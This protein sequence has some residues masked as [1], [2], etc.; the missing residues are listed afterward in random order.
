MCIHIISANED[1]EVHSQ[2]LQIALYLWSRKLPT[3]QRQPQEPRLRV[4][5]VRLL[6]GLHRNGPT[7]MFISQCVCHIQAGVCETGLHLHAQ[8]T[9]VTRI[10]IYCETFS[11]GT[12]GG[13][14][15]GHCGLHGRVNDYGIIFRLFKKY[16]YPCSNSP[17]RSFS[18][19][20]KSI[21]YN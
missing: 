20:T 21:M 11:A 18:G 12:I 6:G 14:H 3:Q 9:R 4:D 17:P 16:S 7:G 13:L 10:R 1:L 5:R 15:T 8:T 2:R 19:T